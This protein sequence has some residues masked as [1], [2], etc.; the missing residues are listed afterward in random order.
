M[1]R[2][3]ITVVLLV[4]AASIA[5]MIQPASVSSA[6]DRMEPSPAAADGCQRALLTIQITDLPS[7]AKAKVFIVGPQDGPR[8]GKQ[9]RMKES[10]T[11]CVDPGLYTVAAQPVHTVGLTVYP[12]VDMA[13]LRVSPGH[14]GTA[15]VSY[16]NQVTDATKILTPE[17]LAAT[18]ISVT[19]DQSTFVFSRQPVAG[20]I[21][22]GDILNA[23]P[24]AEVPTGVLRKVSGVTRVG[25]RVIVSTVRAAVDEAIPQGSFSYSDTAFSVR[26]RA[27][28]A[29]VSSAPGDPIFTGGLDP[30]CSTVNGGH[31]QLEYLVNEPVLTKSFDVSWSVL[32]GLTWDFAIGLHAYAE[33]DL[34]GSRTVQ[35]DVGKELL[36]PI[37]LFTLA[38]PTGTPVFIPVT[39]VLQLKTS[40]SGQID[41]GESSRLEMRFAAGYTI[42]AHGDEESAAVTENGFSCD[43]PVAPDATLCTDVTLNTAKLGGS[44]AWN[45]VDL[46]ATLAVAYTG[47]LIGGPIAG[48][49]YGINRK[50]E[51]AGSHTDEPRWML[52][53]GVD[54]EVGL[55]FD[56]KFIHADVAYKLPALENFLLLVSAPVITTESLPPARAGERTEFQL[57]AK[58]GAPRIPPDSQYTWELQGEP[59]WLT[60]NADT[61]LLFADPPADTPEGPIE[62]TVKVVNRRAIAFRTAEKT[63]TIDVVAG[64]PRFTVNSTDDLVDAFPGNGRCDISGDTGICTLRAAVQEANAGDSAATIVVPPGMY[65]L[66]RTGR[67]EDAAATGDLDLRKDMNI[68]GVPGGAEST[69]IAGLGD[70]IFQIPSGVTVRIDD[71]TVSNGTAPGRSVTPASFGGGI[72]ND[73]N[74]TFSQGVLRNNSAVSVGGAIWN[75]GA[76]TIIDSTIRN[77]NGGGSGGGALGHFGTMARLINTV[78]RQNQSSFGGGLYN[79]GPLEL[80]DTTITDNTAHEFHGAG[81]I[82]NFT[83][84]VVWINSRV[85]G[86]HGSP[87]DEA[88]CHTTLGGQPSQILPCG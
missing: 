63:L 81:G 75:T 80:R 17:T 8:P 23:L 24:T 71:V 59:S 26:R 25:G 53:S 1:V 18:L 6:N 37:E 62:F 52:T 9:R 45:I 82:R 87:P 15:S 69:N 13:S 47:G 30:G 51:L 4:L 85:F 22:V 86:N 84:D 31:V 28:G 20:G 67:D 78:V 88:D 40:L 48:P 58:G 41:F 21:V 65:T 73:G 34:V 55:Q 72:Y 61:G 35:C 2:G 68:Q 5:G 56:W 39:G 38:I 49:Y 43:P 27:S 83:S 57:E 19:D 16:F 29:R 50:L 74:L 7:G 11:L 66:S 54:Q 77:N 44:L 32:A 12:T 76:V 3:P 60:V 36:P 42:S 64:N 79:A 33:L 10:A 46:T 70:R 14:P